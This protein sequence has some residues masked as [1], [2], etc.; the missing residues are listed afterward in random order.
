MADIDTELVISGQPTEDEKLN[1]LIIHVQGFILDFI[2]KG[3]ARSINAGN[4]KTEFAAKISGVV[5]YFSLDGEIKESFKKYNQNA[6]V[7]KK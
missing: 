7:K 4:S 5:W 3:Q 2:N 1:L 6:T